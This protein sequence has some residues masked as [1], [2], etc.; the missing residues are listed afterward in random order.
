ML[1]SQINPFIRFV[2]YL[3]INPERK[4]V[5][6]VGLDA[7]LYYGLMG[8]AKIKVFDVEYELHENSLIIINSGI[9]Y[10]T[11]SPETY[12]KI[13]QFNFDFT[14]NAEQVAHPIIPVPT[15]LFKRDMLLD[16]QEIEDCPKLSG[17]L[18]IQN[19]VSIQN[20]LNA[21]AGEYM[22]Q[23]LYHKQKIG[24][25]L[26]DCLCDIVRYSQ[27]GAPTAQ[28]HKYNDILAYVRTHY[29]EKLTNETLGKLFGYHP[30]YINHLVKQS[31]GLSL[32][33]Y[34]ICIR[35][36]VATN[37]LTNSKLTTDE[38]SAA[39]GFYDTAY[40]CKLFKKHF[41]TT[42]MKYRNL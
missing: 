13:L 26:G 14:R 41:C 4:F 21:I 24:H 32:H 31:T 38:I 7:R 42:P 19:I 27:I 16:R 40:F 20:R 30:N 18:Y 36:E 3:E 8:C 35:L 12:A 6:T 25:M 1:F 15:P 9:P 11:L 39:C 2:Q 28:K 10:H 37:L 17:V 23:L 33:Q 5:E 34:I 22:N 29:A